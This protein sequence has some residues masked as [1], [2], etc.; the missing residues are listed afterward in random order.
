MLMSLNKKLAIFFAVQSLTYGV[1]NT[2]K[3][4]QRAMCIAPYTKY[5]VR[6]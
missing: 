1:R 5:E 3:S 2:A 4:V 6:E